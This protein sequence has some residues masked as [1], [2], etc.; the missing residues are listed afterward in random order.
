MKCEIWTTYALGE[1]PKCIWEGE[2]THMPREMDSIDIANT[3]YL[4]LV[5][6]WIPAEN[7]VTV[8]VK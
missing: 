7:R 3:S 6:V 4:V 5:S 8:R 2:I 1:A